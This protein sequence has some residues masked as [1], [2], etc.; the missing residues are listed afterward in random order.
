[1]LREEK[2]NRICKRYYTRKTR[3]DKEEPGRKADAL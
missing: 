3:A 1:M 2:K